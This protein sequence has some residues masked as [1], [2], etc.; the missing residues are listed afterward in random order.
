MRVN[1]AKICHI[2][3]WN[4]IFPSIHDFSFKYLLIQLVTLILLNTNPRYGIDLPLDLFH[5]LIDR[6]QD[7]LGVLP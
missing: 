3:I 7:L 4:Y 2:Y 6:K 5:L 1:N